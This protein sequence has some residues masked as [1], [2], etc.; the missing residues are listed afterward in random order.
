MGSVQFPR[1]TGRRRAGPRMGRLRRIGIAVAVLA[2]SVFHFGALSL[3]E[4]KQTLRAAGHPV[5]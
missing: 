5:R 1:L 2:A 3:G 4:V